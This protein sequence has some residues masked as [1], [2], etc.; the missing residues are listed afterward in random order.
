MPSEHPHTRALFAEAFP[1]PLPS[2]PAV[3]RVFETHTGR[4][5]SF[6]PST[7]MAALVRWNGHGSLSAE[8]RD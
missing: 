6:R 8:L 1:A 2:R 3:G 5:R 4:R 7:P